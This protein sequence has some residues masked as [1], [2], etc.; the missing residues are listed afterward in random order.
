[1]G[2]GRRCCS[3]EKLRP[4][5][6]GN[7]RQKLS[8]AGGLPTEDGTLLTLSNIVSAIYYATDNGAKVIN[9]SFEISHISNELIR[10]LSIANRNGVICIAS[11]QRR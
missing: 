2:F 11:R 10:P 9:M 6:K 7:T 1:M 8:G 3:S 5:F 4:S